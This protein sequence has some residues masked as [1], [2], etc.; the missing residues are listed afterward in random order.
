VIQPGRL[1]DPREI[2]VL[3]DRFEVEKKMILIVSNDPEGAVRELAPVKEK[4]QGWI[5]GVALGTSLKKDVLHLKRISGLLSA[6]MSFVV[7]S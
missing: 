4:I 3:I 6:P 1:F 5:G 2:S 7:G